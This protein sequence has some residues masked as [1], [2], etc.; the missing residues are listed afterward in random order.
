MRVIP[1]MGIDVLFGGLVRASVD[2]YG[3]CRGPRGRPR[4]GLGCFRDEFRMDQ[5]GDGARVFTSLA[6]AGEVLDTCGIVCDVT[7]Q[8]RW[9]V[10]RGYSMDPVV[11][12]LWKLKFN[13]WRY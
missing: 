1:N 7:M 2:D 13:L 4:A 3:A 6:W 11:W 8:L 5:D 10:A 12:L 9:S